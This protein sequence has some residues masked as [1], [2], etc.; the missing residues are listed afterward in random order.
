MLILVAVPTSA[1]AGPQKP[2]PGSQR[3][4]P[5]FGAEN[6]TAIDMHHSDG[7][8][9]PRVFVALSSY[10]E[11][12][13]VRVE[14]KQKGKVLATMPCKRSSPG[15]AC[16]S[17]KPLKAKGA[18]DADIIFEDDTDDKEYLVRTLKVTIEQY[19]DGSDTKWNVAADDLLGT[20]YAWH[21]PK[22][23]RANSSQG[24]V[25]FQFWVA[26]SANFNKA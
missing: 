21:Y 3:S 13:R 6:Y 23:G 24:R 16:T 20:A 14:W 18:I 2:L 1:L 12:D 11:N 25:H 26:A 19:K 4:T 10:G 22:H 17:D 7:G 5:V 9:Q 15:F 8:Y